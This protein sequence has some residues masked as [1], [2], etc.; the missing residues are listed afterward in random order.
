MNKSAP[1]RRATLANS[2]ILRSLRLAGI[3]GALSPLLLAQAPASRQTEDASTTDRDQE[4]ISL[5]PF[6]VTASNDVGYGAGTEGSSG[7]LRIPYLDSAQTSTIVTSELM[8]D[9]GLSDSAQ[10]MLFIPNAEVNRTQDVQTFNIRGLNTTGLYMDGFFA[11]SLTFIDTAFFDRIEVVK[12]PSSVGFG[13]GD[14]AGFINF[15]SKRPQYNRR[16]LLTLSAGTG[17]PRPNYRAVLDHN[18]F[19]GKSQKTAYRFVAQ[20]GGGSTTR[21]GSEFERRGALLAVDHK[22]GDAGDLS[23]TAHYFQNNSGYAVGNLS[24]SDPTLQYA[25]RSTI[26]VDQKVPVHSVDTTFNFAGTGT[27]AD[28][29]LL[30]G[31]LNLRLGRHWNIRQAAKYS[32]SQNTS[33]GTAGN[34]SSVRRRAS[35][36]QLIFTQSAARHFASSKSLSYQLDM[37]FEQSSKFLDSNYSLLFGGDISYDRNVGQSQAAVANGYQT[38]LYL[39]FNPNTPITFPTIPL[40]QTGSHTDGI[41]WSPYVQAQANF[42]DK[43]FQATAAARYVYQDVD[44]VSNVTGRV[45][46]IKNRTPLLPM[47]SLLYKPT[48]N[49]SLYALWSKFEQ[50]QTV[51]TTY[52]IPGGGQL[53]I[54]D[55]RSQLIS[56]RK[57]TT[58][59]KEL[60][61]KTMLFDGKLTLSGAIYRTENSG[62]GRLALLP[63]PTY[64]S[65]QYNFTSV[66]VLKGYEVQIAGR[67]TNHLTIMLGGGIQ[68]TE[69]QVPAP[70][71]GDIVN[72][73]YP[74]NADNVSVNIKYSF[75]SKPRRGLTLIA[76]AKSF[77]KGWSANA[78]NVPA[79]KDL[80]YPDTVTVAT[81]SARYGFRDGRDSLTLRVNNAFHKEAVVAGGYLA[82]VSGRLFTLEYTK[83]F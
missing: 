29:A 31:I 65:V 83:E 20:Y 64:G 24:F 82:A 5:S 14:P 59:L 56:I 25:F 10:A 36:G 80:P 41:N 11:H 75:E 55:P 15:V 35:D 46:P 34:V 1:S 44:S 48:K 54:T 70:P 16:T 23:V 53:P 81:L 52:V 2:R 17:G 26:T 6:S 8:E 21:V 39:A 3:A 18:G 13:R 40:S 28:Y 43:K 57:P 49:I 37:L 33:Q 51:V 62:V 72:L 45:T 73:P 32:E 63:D 50:Q 19:F 7:R 60:G 12:G 47:A 22:F 27:E 67:V 38:Q 77:L 78:N 42:L 74:G 4:T 71:S 61:I 68:K 69:A 66:D 30:S 76:G 9:F 79:L 58:E